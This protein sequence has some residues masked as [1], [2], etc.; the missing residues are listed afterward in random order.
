MDWTANCKR[1]DR[2][3][4]GQNVTRNKNKM[5]SVRN[6][7]WRVRVTIVAVEMQQWILSVVEL[8]VT[9]CCTTVLL[10]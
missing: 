10:L 3:E 2:Q 5:S 8:R 7:Q 9:E 4:K 6:M 1:R